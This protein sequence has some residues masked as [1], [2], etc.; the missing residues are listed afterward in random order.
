MAQACGIIDQELH[1]ISQQLKRILNDQDAILAGIESDPNLKMEGS[2]RREE[3]SDVQAILNQDVQLSKK[4]G[5]L[6][7]LNLVA[8]LI[9]EFKAN[10]ELWE[11]ENCY[12]SLQNL[13]KR[14]EKVD[15]SLFPIQFQGLL[16][17]HIDSLHVDLLSRIDKVMR[18]FWDISARSVTFNQKI[19]VDRDDVLLEYDSFSLFLKSCFFS[20]D[21]FEPTSWF[22]ATMNMGDAKDKVTNLLAT[23]FNEWVRLQTVQEK[24]KQFLFSANVCLSLKGCTLGASENPGNL[25]D[26][27]KSFEALVMFMKDVTTAE[28]T[29]VIL[30]KLGNTLLTEIVKFVKQNSSHL[31]APGTN[32]KNSVVSLNTML[33][34]LSHKGGKS[35]Q[36]AGRE[37]D[38]LINDDSVINNLM[39][40]K[41]L[42]E[43][44]SAIRKQF[45][46][47]DWKNKRAIKVK[48]RKT[49]LSVL[50]GERSK[51]HKTGTGTSDD[52]WAW[53]HDNVSAEVGEDEDGWGSET[54]I[55]LDSKE[56]HDPIV[57]S[58]KDAE[59]ENDWQN[60][61]DEA[62]SLGDD[63]DDTMKVTQVPDLFKQIFTDFEAGCEKIGQNKISAVVDYKR[64]V[65]LTSFMAMCMC[66]Y[67]EWWQLYHDVD[68]ILSESADARKLYRLHELNSHFV[69]THVENLK[70]T[71]RKIMGQQL[72]NFQASDKSP[73]WGITI[74]SLLPY[75]E[76]AALPALLKL[77][78]PRILSGFLE[79]LY[80]DCLVNEILSWRMISE[81]NSENLAE[82]INLLL[83]GTDVRQV[84]TDPKI[85]HSREKLEIIGRVLT[86]HLTDIMDMFSNGDFYLFST[87]EV[88]QWI[89][90]LFADTG[91]RRECI[92]EIRTI[93]EEQ[94]T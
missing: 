78:N 9:D 65:L 25:D 44:I 45:A 29:A 24:L 3:P 18:Q 11:L 80:A 27:L 72:Q 57:L 83:T 89:V 71:A 86:A 68:F 38:N 12:Y 94:G 15:M 36:Y 87:D 49:S 64:N 22:V 31:F 54:E 1:C 5:A 19:A 52:E 62:A 39:L 2:A 56:A 10:F 91:L 90:M 58:K 21:H 17:V 37:L 88:V 76:T 20:Q 8:N 59:G 48:A 26:T 73:N 47:G 46:S 53:D 6:K 82:L 14:L 41:L 60:A 75:I 81:K 4:L 13:H 55:A 84:E 40:D 69:N 70:K 28:D 30:A 42:Q 7:E 33:T 92:D 23:A 66:R 51:A 79:Y 74:E 32:Y 93:R 35:W 43:Q 85:V 34:E 67:E 61:W 50:S 63:F 77:R 16:K